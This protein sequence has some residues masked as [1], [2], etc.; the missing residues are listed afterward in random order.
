MNR[1]TMMMLL[2]LGVAAAILYFKTKKASAA[3]IPNAITGGASPA[4]LG[5]VSRY[6][7]ATAPT[8]SAYTAERPIQPGESDY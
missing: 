3:S 6:G 5:N 4:A 8:A 2:G 1:K 7:R